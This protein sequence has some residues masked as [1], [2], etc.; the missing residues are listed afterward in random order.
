MKLR[1]YEN[2][3][4]RQAA[5]PLDNINYSFVGLA[6]EVGEAMEWHKKVNLRAQIC[7][8]GKNDLKS[9][10]GDVLHYTVRIARHY[11]W[12]VKDLINDNVEKIEKRVQERN[13]PKQAIGA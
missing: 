11:G 3:V 4:E 12:T 1:D 9:E 2:W 7:K 6:G 10:L 5:Y 13:T 8:L